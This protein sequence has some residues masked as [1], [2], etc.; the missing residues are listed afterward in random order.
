MIT[1]VFYGYRGKDKVVE[2]VRNRDPLTGEINYYSAAELEDP[3]DVEVGDEEAYKVSL[4][5]KTIFK[6]EDVEFDEY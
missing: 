3:E 5:S 6:N 1:D 2:W 4:V